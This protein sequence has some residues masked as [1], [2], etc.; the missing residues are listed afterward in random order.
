[1][2]E[3]TV[4]LRAIE[5]EDVEVMYGA[6][7]D[8][9]CWYASDITAP[10][11]RRL[12][13]EYASCYDADPWNSG[14]LRLIAEDGDG[15]NIIG[16]ADFYELDARHSRGFAGVYILPQFRN[17]GYGEAMLGAMVEYAHTHLMLSQLAARIPADN[18]ASTSLFEKVGFKQS[19]T[20]RAWHRAGGRVHDVAL[21]Q[22]LF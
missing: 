8:T 21:Y 17:Q 9:N 6:D 15:G 10:L 3:K 12:L 5:P 13:R 18:L 20:L 11:S 4:L 2:I 14:Q 19:G 22:L 7:N 1:M 16:V